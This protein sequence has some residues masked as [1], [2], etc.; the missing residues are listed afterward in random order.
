MVARVEL[1]SEMTPKAGQ[2][3][4]GVDVGDDEQVDSLIGHSA[5]ELYCAVDT[6]TWHG[7]PPA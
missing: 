1:Q 4:D 5:L 7:N 2:I 6:D 3:V